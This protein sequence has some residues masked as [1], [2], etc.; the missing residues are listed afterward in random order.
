[1]MTNKTSER[2]NRWFDELNMLQKIYREREVIAY[3]KSTLA[4]VRRKEQRAA[5]RQQLDN[6]Q[7]VMQYITAK[8]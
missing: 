5:R 6:D 4:D 3:V 8:K 7:F 1:M 2:L